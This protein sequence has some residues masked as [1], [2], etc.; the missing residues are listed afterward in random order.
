MESEQAIEAVAVDS[1]MMT[2]AQNGL[3]L[4]SQGFTT[5]QELIRSGILR[6]LA[7]P[8]SK[9]VAAYFPSAK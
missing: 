6:Q 3:T 9:K 2:L 8:Q 5:K 7:F 4:V 1:G